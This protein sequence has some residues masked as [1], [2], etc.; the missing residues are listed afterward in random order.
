MTLLE[1][2][3]QTTPTIEADLGKNMLSIPDQRMLASQLKDDVVAV[4]SDVFHDLPDSE[5]RLG[6]ELVLADGGMYRLGRIHENRADKSNITYIPNDPSQVSVLLE[7]TQARWEDVPSY[8][9][10]SWK[11]EEEPQIFELNPNLTPNIDASQDENAFRACAEFLDAVRADVF[12][13]QN[14]VEQQSPQQTLAA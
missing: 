5:P 3:P 11:G 1:G 13:P 9:L 14:S 12:Q 2:T 8:L 6:E 10:K 7:T 4:F